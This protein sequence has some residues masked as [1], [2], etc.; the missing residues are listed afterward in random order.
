MLIDFDGILKMSWVEQSTNSIPPGDSVKPRYY[1]KNGLE[2]YDIQRASMGLKKYQGY[3]EGCVQKYLWRWEEKNGK[4]D[5][6]KA[7]EYLTKL[8]E[9]VE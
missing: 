7:I 6:Q 9:T 3:L 5:L 1:R 8:L 4:E 2:C